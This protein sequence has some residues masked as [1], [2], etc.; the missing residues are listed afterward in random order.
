MV[1][2]VFK[3]YQQLISHGYSRPRR[4]ALDC[5]NHALAAADTYMGT[6]RIV[7][8][9]GNILTI[10]DESFNLSEVEDIYVVGAGKGSFPIAQALDEIL[11]EKITKG[12]VLV[13]QGE[14]RRLKHIEIRETSHPVPNELSLQ[15]GMDIQKI[16]LSAGEKDLVLV[17]L[18]GGCSSLMVLPVDEVSLQD[19][20]KVNRLL[21]KTGAQIHEM[22]AVRKHL[23]KIKGGRIIQMI[24]PATSVTLTQYTAPDFLPWPDPALPDPSTFGDAIEV[25]KKYELYE[26]IP[27]NVREYLLKGLSDPALE[28]PKDFTGIK[29]YMFDTGNQ[30]N[31]CLAAVDHAKEIGY[32]AY[33]LSTKIEGESRHVGM[34]LAGIA[35]EIQMYCRPF[36]PPCVL[37]SAGETTVSLGDKVGHGGPNQELAL[38]FAQGIQEY[39]NIALV[40]ID[41]EGT[42]GPTSIA[43]GI[44]DGLTMQRAK[45]LKIDIF[46]A[47]KCH[48]SSTALKSLEDA[49]I[50]GETGTNVV[51]LRVL[52]V[53]R[54]EE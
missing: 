50:T 23:S 26:K 18:T 34:V 5:L 45:E 1:K 11:G 6:K 15:G 4:V 19:K 39:K 25:L 8:L 14:K 36:A 28:T 51:N 10:G 38:G 46:D 33:V 48:D 27:A 44:A 37:V 54:R 17:C 47:L 35:K 40:S 41:S 16:A 3:N 9:Q 32:N 12:L 21:L 20:I 42:D 22:N 13:K 2:N 52:V 29:T 53:E 7:D 31:A 30:R 43:G 24:H 49:V